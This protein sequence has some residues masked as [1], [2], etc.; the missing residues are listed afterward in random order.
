MFKF[1][2]RTATAS[3]TI[4][5]AL[6]VH[7][8]AIGGPGNAH[9]VLN[10]RGASALLVPHDH[11][12]PVT[13]ASTNEQLAADGPSLHRHMLDSK[14]VPD[15]LN[16]SVVVRISSAGWVAAMERSRRRDHRNVAL[17]HF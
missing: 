3:G 17:C 13:N 9:L 5:V 14:S 1:A 16:G 8:E 6:D 11:P 7:P 15:G 2:R 12:Y 10:V 4:A